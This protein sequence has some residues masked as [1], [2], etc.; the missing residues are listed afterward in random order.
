MSNE[1]KNK[2]FKEEEVGLT[3]KQDV[4]DSPEST[5][6]GARTEAKCFQQVQCGLHFHYL[7]LLLRCFPMKP[8]PWSGFLETELLADHG[9]QSG[10]FLVLQDMLVPIVQPPNHVTTLL[11]VP[12]TKII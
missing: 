10:L 12:L 8:E 7:L 6:H 9:P 3:K 2:K 1:E 5:K 4:P 11:T